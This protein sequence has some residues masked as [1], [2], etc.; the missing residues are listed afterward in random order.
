MSGSFD[1]ATFFDEHDTQDDFGLSSLSTPLRR[2]N[3]RRLLEEIKHG[4]TVLETRGITKTISG[5]GRQ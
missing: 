4:D 3:C 1:F 5:R 2:D